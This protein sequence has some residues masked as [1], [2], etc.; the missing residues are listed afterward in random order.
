MALTTSVN[1]T[2][3]VPS[4]LALMLARDRLAPGWLGSGLPATGTPVVGLTLTPAAA[5]ILLVSG[6]ISLAL[7]IPL[8]ALVLPHFLPRPA[9]LLPP[10]AIPPLCA[11]VTASIPLSLQRVAAVAS[12]A[13]MGA[14]IALQVIEDSKVLARSRLSDRIARHELTTVELSALWA[15][16]GLAI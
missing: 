4:R 6:P 11:S 10:R 13:A 2:M 5:A 7:N 12:M 8:F 3:L 14:L 9:L 16:L 15:V 1:S